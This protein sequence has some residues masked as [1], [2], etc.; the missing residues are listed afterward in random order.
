MING[1]FGA[2]FFLFHTPKMIQKKLCDFGIKLRDCIKNSINAC[3]FQKKVVPLQRIL[4]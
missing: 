1:A 3:I 2:P 4:D